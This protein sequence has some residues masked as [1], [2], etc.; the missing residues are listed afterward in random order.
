MGA[1]VVHNFEI[2]SHKIVYSV[3]FDNN[4]LHSSKINDLGTHFIID[5]N[6]FSLV[7]NI[8]KTDKIVLIDATES[9]KSFDNISPIISSLLDL[10]LKR[11]SK[12]VAIGGGITQD[13]TCFIANNFMRGIDWTFVP[14]TLLAQAD[15]CI[16]S[17]SSINFGKYKN[18]LGSFTPPNKVVISNQFLDTLSETEIKSGIGEIIKLFIIDNKTI[19]YNCIRNNL[20]KFL[21]DALQIKKIFIEED[22]FDKGIRNILNY[23]HCFGHAIE[24]ASNFAIPHG[25][26]VSIG[27]DI[28]NKFSLHRNLINDDRYLRLHNVLKDSYLGFTDFSINRTDLRSALLKDKKNTGNKINIILP[29]DT[30]IEKRGFNNSDDFWHSVDV[31]IKS[32]LINYH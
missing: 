28:A 4:L 19:D 32:V 20:D 2:K 21:F 31:S 15:S 29:V 8:L 9:T 14:T 24:S 23:G 5:R 18:L 3:E 30:I 10:N 17:K 22:E 11:D 27:M 1:S 6:V 7:Q 26:A 12:L 16:G 25:I 13:I